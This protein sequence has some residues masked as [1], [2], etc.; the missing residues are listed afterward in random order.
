MLLAIFGGSRARGS[1]QL[2]AAPGGCWRLL[3]TAGGPGG[4]PRRLRKLGLLKQLQLTR[5]LNF[6]S[7]FL[8]FFRL[9]FVSLP[10]VFSSV[11]ER[12]SKFFVPSV[13]FLL[14]SILFPWLLY[15]RK[16][17][18]CGGCVWV[19]WVVLLG[20]LSLGA[21]GGALFVK[22]RVGFPKCVHCAPIH[23]GKVGVALK[24]YE[25]RLLQIT[26]HG[27]CSLVGHGPTISI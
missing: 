14:Q 27:L 10:L 3:A 21:F 1:C 2:L 11:S 18:V 17:V 20:S 25:R 15:L 13:L 19:V 6:V 5:A 26:P 24:S 12:V 23:Y 16:L 4:P 8:V 22:V 9:R 7:L